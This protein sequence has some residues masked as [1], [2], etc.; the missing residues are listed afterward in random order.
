MAKRTVQRAAA[1]RLSVILAVFW[2]LS[3]S[4]L[5]WAVAADMLNQVKDHMSSYIAYP[6]NRENQLDDYEADLPGDMEINTMSRIPLYYAEL[7]PGRS[8]PFMTDPWLGGGISNKSSLWGHWSLIFGLEPAAVYYDTEWNVI[9]KS[10]DYLS[11][12]YSE[13]EFSLTPEGRGYILLEEPLKALTKLGEQ[14]PVALQFFYKSKELPRLRMTGRFQGNQFIPV[15]VEVRYDSNKQWETLLTLEDTEEA[16]TV[17]IYGWN[18]SGFSYDSR[19]LRIG[20]VTYENLTEYILNFDYDSLTDEVYG[21][22]IHRR[23][24][25]FDAVIWYG[26]SGSDVYGDYHFDLAVRCS[27]ILYAVLRLWPTYLGSLVLMLTGLWWYLSWTRKQVTEPVA[28]LIGT[29]RS[30][31]NMGNAGKLWEIRLLQDQVRGKIEASVELKNQVDQLR[32]QL[33]YAKSAEEK[34]RQLVSDITHELKTPL[35]VIHSYAECLMEGVAPEK[36]EQQLSVILEEVRNMDSLVLQMLELSR[37]EAGKVT[38]KREQISLT[39]L[40]QQV[41]ERLCPLAAEKELVMTWGKREEAVLWADTE[42]ILQ[43]VTNLIGNAVK[44]TP[45]GGSIE[46]DVERQDKCVRFAVTNTAQP[47]SPEEL[48]K[49]WD[50]FYRVDH[51]RSEAGTGLGLSLV[52]NIIRLHGGS[53][54]ARNISFRYHNCVDTKLEFSFQIPL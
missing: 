10:G 11:F 21:E 35:A 17:T 26:G 22:Q 5:T 29:L 2:M 36:R 33:E 19:P 30:G 28:R 14:S 1:L 4:L 37:L 49:V 20:G 16:P 3:M 54:H 42:R 6:P 15:Q 45:K 43:A 8:L 23:D 24:D 25:L 31:T 18:L 27:P 34:R 40:T 47:L 48:E 9:A 7:C 46:V 51:A 12:A 13:K 44:Y 50:S 41:M 39:A 53:C 38:L 32:T 52:K